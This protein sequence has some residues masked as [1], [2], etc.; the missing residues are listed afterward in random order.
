MMREM[1]LQTDPQAMVAAYRERLRG[2]LPT[3]RGLALSRRGL[4]APLVRVTRSSDW[5][6]E[7]NPWTERHR[8]PVLEGGFFAEVVYG[9]EPLIVDDLEGRVA[10][11]DPAR[12]YV[13]GMRSMMAL[14]NYDQGHA[15]NWNL[16]F[17]REPGAFDRE[18]LPE[19]VWMSNLFGRATQNLVLS[20]EVRSAYAT[21]DRELKVVAD[22]QRS[23]LPTELPR[24]ERLDVAA[25]YRT[26]RWA[27]GDYYDFFPLPEGRWGLLVADVSG[28]GTPAAVLM[29]ITHAIAHGY[30]GHPTPPGE[31]LG[32]VNAR[33][34]RRYT[35]ENDRFVT[36]FYG[37]F[38]P[39][40]RTLRYASAG[41]NPP[42]I[43][44]CEDGTIHVL[45]AAAGLPLG[46][47]PEG[48]YDD[49]TV[50]LVVGDQLVLYTDG[51]TEALD[52]RGR[53][54]GVGRLDAAVANCGIGAQDLVDAVVAA[55]EAFCGE[56]PINDDRTLV[57]AKVR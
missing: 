43:K 46:L 2:L 11:D 3:H 39:A 48:V 27:G 40:S 54:F 56:E 7:I 10:E 31:L 51:I 22:I 50:Q 17:H 55:V 26:S 9:D 38:D 24:I 20:A 47:D 5:T 19:R 4:E 33:L 35:A 41:H 52:A 36:A 6:E 21:V 49:A 1:S 34:A 15:L 18:S 57:V 25:Y 29:A 45:D 13:E 14:P 8:L 28:H 16:A 23:L 30:P 44:R 32:H 37:I 42:R 12:P 53:L